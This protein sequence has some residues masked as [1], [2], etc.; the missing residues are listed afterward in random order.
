MELILV[1]DGSTD[2]SGQICDAY[3]EKDSRVRVIHQE[4]GGVSRARDAGIDA[5]QG[6][7]L[8]FVDSDDWVEPNHVEVLLPIENEKTR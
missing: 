7:Y 1:D 6:E 8:L 2:H 4:N 5:A 3:V